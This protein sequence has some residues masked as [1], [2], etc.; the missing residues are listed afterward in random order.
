MSEP[1]KIPQKRET[2][3]SMLLQKEQAYLTIKRFLFE[4]EDNQS[5]F[6]ERFLAAKLEMGLASVRAAL[7]RM[8]AE[9]IVETI[10]KA[11]IRL[12]QISHNEIIEFFEMR[13]VIEPYISREIAGRLNPSQCDVLEALIADQRKAVVERDTIAYH[14]F[15]L[16]LHETLADMHGNREMIRALGQM[17]DKMFRL[18]RRIH[19]T[20]PE[21]LKR[22]VD[23][24]HA[25]V[26]A[27]CNGR[28]RDAEM[29]MWTHLSWGRDQTLDPWGRIE[30]THTAPEDR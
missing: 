8:R 15:D 17:R 30:V 29:A 12:P 3:G 24:H 22:N 23:Q 11:G 2:G 14:K 10:P 19:R 4:E 7:E 16:E 18:S 25:V 27:V 13:L 26:E 28:P 5:I 9:R 21:R 6:S 20:H 1:L